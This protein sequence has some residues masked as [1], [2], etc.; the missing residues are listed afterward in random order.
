[1]PQ[2]IISGEQSRR[3]LAEI[4]RTLGAGKFFLI[5]GSPFDRLPLRV[6]FENIGTSYVRF[7]GFTSNPVYEDVCRG[8]DLFRRECCD[9]IV[10]VGGG[11]AIDVAKCVRQ[12]SVLDS[13]KDY[14]AQE[15][16]DS[17]I[18]MI[19]VP[20]TAGTGSE[21]THFA[22]VYKNGRKYSVA[23]RSMLPD[24]VILDA[25]LLRTLPLYQKKC[26][27]LDALC[28][29][30]ESWWSVKSTEESTEYSKQAIEMILQ[31]QEDYIQR[32]SR[33]AAEKIL[34]A[35]NYSGRAINITQTTAPHAMSYK[36]TSLYRLPHGHAVAL[37]LPEVWDYMSTH[38]EQCIDS[39]GVEYVRRV[40]VD[41]ARTM[42]GGDSQRAIER[43]RMLLREF[44][45]DKP[46]EH[47]RQK[48]LETLTKSV[49]P[50]RL[51]NNPVKLN[52]NTIMNLYRHILKAE[53][54]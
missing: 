53:R 9:T 15:Y 43:F 54:D 39:R 27:L 36:L 21:S 22:V 35:A 2:T 7:S 30:I 20:T 29:A 41:I 40:L 49:D 10:A 14:L 24:Y 17:R 25:D 23:Q 52:E 45:I 50:A 37:C 16:Q 11:S 1:M 12:F 34:Q 8:V 5:C 31:W 44:G 48:V 51:D 13:S 38:L 28:Q 32:N 19:A 6:F 26:T 42:G 4:F 33:E 47:Q 18:P 46:T 3:Q